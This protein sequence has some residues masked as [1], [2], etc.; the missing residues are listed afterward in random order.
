MLR[1]LLDELAAAQAS[2]GEQRQPPCT[3]DRLER[4]GRQVREELG[5]EPPDEYAAFLRAQDGLNHNGLLVYASETAPVVGARDATIQGIVEANLGWRDHEPMVAYLVFGEG[6]MDLYV[7]NVETGAYHVMDRV[8]G[9]L[10]ERYPSFDQL[11][12][13]AIRSHL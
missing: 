13:A 5:A 6:N 4:L 9:N 2:Y 3:D 12:D 11:L 1:Q 7:R 10:V 8:P